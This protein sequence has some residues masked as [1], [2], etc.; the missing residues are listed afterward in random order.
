MKRWS[1]RWGRWYEDPQGE[2]VRYEDIPEPESHWDT[3]EEQAAAQRLGLALEEWKSSGGQITDV[4]RALRV[5]VR[6][7]DTHLL[8]RSLDSVRLEAH[9]MGSGVVPS[10]WVDPP[11][12]FPATGILV[13]LNVGTTPVVLQPGQSLRVGP[14]PHGDIVVSLVTTATE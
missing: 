10:A 3:P 8:L 14:G 4:L 9:S 11:R 13:Y 5:L 2:W 12:S 7:A 6:G 1:V